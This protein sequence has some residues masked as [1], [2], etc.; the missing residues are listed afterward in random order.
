[1]FR[2]LEDIEREDQR[3]GT[4][5]QTFKIEHHKSNNNGDFVDSDST[6]TKKPTTM[7][8][9]EEDELGFAF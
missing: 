6:N 5:F 3:R 2:N 1:M 4:H 8:I 7:A 9:N